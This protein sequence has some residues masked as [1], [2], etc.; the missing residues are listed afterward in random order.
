[1]FRQ[2][3]QGFTNS[4]GLPVSIVGE[5]RSRPI[6]ADVNQDNA[7]RTDQDLYRLRAAGIV[8]QVLHATPSQ[9]GRPP[10]RWQNPH[11]RTAGNPGNPTKAAAAHLAP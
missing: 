2:T 5:P 9:G 3:L 10:N 7:A 6:D 8:S 11:P 4:V 1:M